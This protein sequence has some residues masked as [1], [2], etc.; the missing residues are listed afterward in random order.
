MT[1]MAS[2]L[3][4][5]WSDSKYF[6]SKWSDGSESPEDILSSSDGKELSVD[7]GHVVCRGDLN[8]DGIEDLSQ[9]AY[10]RTKD[11][12]VENTSLL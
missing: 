9:F 11:A 10:S 2:G 6:L 7:S 4:I 3:A 1:A 5:A 12:S 8:G